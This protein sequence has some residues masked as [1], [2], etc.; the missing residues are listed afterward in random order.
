MAT[1]EEQTNKAIDILIE[2]GHNVEA[3]YLS[4]FEPSASNLT[5]EEHYNEAHIYLIDLMTK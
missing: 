1:R 4:G 3:A 5:R 2:L